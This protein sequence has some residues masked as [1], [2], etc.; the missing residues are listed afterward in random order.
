[1][2]NII[3]IETIREKARLNKEILQCMETLK[4]LQTSLQ[5]VLRQKIEVERA[6]DLGQYQLESLYKKRDKL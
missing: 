6:I 1:M 3:P 4:K 5:S 2:S